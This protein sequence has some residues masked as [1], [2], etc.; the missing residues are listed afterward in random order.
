MLLDKDLN[1]VSQSVSLGGVVIIPTDTI[2]GFTCDPRNE[3]S[4]RKIINLKKREQKPFIILDSSIER[5]RNVYF[6]ADDFIN[7]TLDILLQEGIWPGKVTVI[8]DKNEDLNFSFLQDFKKIAVRYT[9]N[10]IVNHICNY[11]DYGIVSTSINISGEKQ[12]NNISEIISGW[13][14]S[15]DYILNYETNDNSSSTM[16]ELISEEKSIKFVRISDNALKEKI[17][18]IISGTAK[19]CL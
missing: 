19:I 3:H 9:V 18:K 5:I 13:A 1:T 14:D 15:A 4:V 16:I 7:N 6:K 2:Y 17:E 10:K 11:I 12:M 8:A